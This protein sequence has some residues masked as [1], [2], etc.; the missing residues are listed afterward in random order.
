[1][2]LYP[3]ELEGNLLQVLVLM[4]MPVWCTYHHKETKSVAFRLFVWGMMAHA[5]SNLYW[6]VS[7]V[8]DNDS[9][10]VFKAS[11]TAAIAFFLLW[12]SMFQAKCEMEATTKNLL[13]LMPVSAVVFSIWN[14]VWW[15]LWNANYIIN[16]IWLI[17]IALLT[18]F[19][20]YSL[21]AGGVFTKKHKIAWFCLVAVLFVF[22]LPMYF[23]ESESL[24]YRFSDW[25]CAG[26]W[27]SLILLFTVS[28]FRDRAHRTAWLYAGMLFT[29]YA[30]YMSDGIRYSVFMMVESVILILLMVFF[31]A[32][33]LGERCER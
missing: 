1:M 25:T 27:L 22:E 5:L 2:S 8:L 28:A 11:D 31:R 18:Y 14:Y 20:F 29:L 9:G 23:N 24:I 13:R 10:N 19:V 17:C 33:D 3:F 26:A 6:T 16:F 4:I 30:E 32:E 7:L 21:D 12:V 15:N